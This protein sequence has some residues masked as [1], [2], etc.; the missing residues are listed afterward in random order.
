MV[1]QRGL[2]ITFEG[3]EGSGKTTQIQ[4][5]SKDLTQAGHMVCVTREPGGTS[6]SEQIRNIFLNPNH[7]EMTPITELLLIAAGRAQHVSQVILPGLEA[8]MTV[9]SDRFSDATVA[10]QGYGRGLNVEYLEE[11]NSFGTDGIFPDLTI[12]LD[13][14]PDQAVQRMQDTAPDRMES[15]GNIF[16][17]RVQL[18]PIRELLKGFLA[19]EK[20]KTEQKVPEVPKRCGRPKFNHHGQVLPIFSKSP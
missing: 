10:Y 5:L 17:N 8:G 18:E 20:E 16:F 1:S 9:L 13:I 14:D 3:I 4:R 2:F 15:I 12:I 11:L 7:R 6:I 19:F